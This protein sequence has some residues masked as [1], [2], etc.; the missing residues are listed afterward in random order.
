[1][2]KPLTDVVKIIKEPFK[3]KDYLH[4]TQKSKGI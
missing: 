2:G 1:M 3:S 4:K